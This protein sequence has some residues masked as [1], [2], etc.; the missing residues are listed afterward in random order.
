MSASALFFNCE[1]QRA[2]RTV[3]YPENIMTPR[4]STLQDAASDFLRSSLRD[5]LEFRHMPL[6]YAERQLVRV[7][8]RVKV[9]LVLVRVWPIHQSD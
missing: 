6:D 3:G 1:M 9:A 5:H 4:T 2:L 7:E 8:G